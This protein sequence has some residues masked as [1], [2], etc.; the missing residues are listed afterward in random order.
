MRNQTNSLKA[1]AALNMFRKGSA[2]LFPLLTFTYASHTLGAEGMGIYSFCSSVVSYFALLAS[3][4][5][6]V[7]AVR[8][9]QSVRD[10]PEQLLRFVSEVY[11]INFIMT[12]VA[13]AL[14]GLLLLV[15]G[16]LN[17]YREIVLTL[18]TSLMLGVIGADWVNTLLEDY[19]FITVRY[20]FMQI[21]C[22]GTLILFVK[23]SEN[24][25]Q[26]TLIGVLSSAGAN[27][28][29][30]WYVRRKIPFRLTRHPHIRQHIAPM[31]TLF[32]NS[33]AMTLYIASD[34]VMLGIFMESKFVG[35][36]TVAS[37]AYMSIKE[38][39]NAMILVTVP[40]FSFYVS[41]GMQEKYSQSF[42]R[43]LYSV[44]TLVTPC[45]AG[46]YMEAE[47][48]LYFIGG[49]EYITGT[50][51]LRT[52]ALTLP[53]AV[54]ACLFCHSVLLPYKQERFFLKATLISATVNI[55]LNFLLIPIWGIQAAAL[56]TLLS[57]MIVCG[58]TLY[59]STVYLP[60]LSEGFSALKSSV[61]GIVAITLICLAVNR[62]IYN[63]LLNL[64]V[65]MIASAFA[66]TA[67]I[68]AM[69]NQTAVD[70]VNY[71][72]KII[73]KGIE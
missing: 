31:I 72:R 29:N 57:E 32:S 71:A 47:R 11:T 63:R 28:F 13:Y 46:L 43:I 15:W 34:V 53:A 3:L 5:I 25:Y 30:I 35:Y 26:Y 52:L 14:L 7:Y 70:I 42:S 45:V 64:L 67:I 56:T 20:I 61:F 4:G 60:E 41:H 36:Y 38:I 27:L 68:Y 55:A 54:G 44:I 59:K 62:L 33:L 10:N 50:Q 16:K 65:S 19:L 12:L 40:R 18:S 6:G 58:M 2:I 39:I 23:S 51:A 66:Y 49:S 1:N 48:I 69:G 24:L 21:V 37:K 17:A 73:R 8:E 22:F 9:G